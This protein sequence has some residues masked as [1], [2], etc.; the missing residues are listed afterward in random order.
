MPQ[1]CEPHR[2]EQCGD[3]NEDELAM[4]G[5]DSTDNSSYSTH[6][7]LLFR[8]PEAS[9]SNGGLFLLV[10]CAACCCFDNEASSL[11]PCLV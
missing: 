11:E 5:I 8:A 1:R 10:S 3:G 4:I 2:P 7:V 9:L 6:A